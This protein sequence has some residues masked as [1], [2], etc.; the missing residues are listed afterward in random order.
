MKRPEC[1][2]FTGRRRDICNGE[3]D[4]SLQKINVQRGRWNLPPLTEAE[5]DPRQRPKSFI[6]PLTKPRSGECSGCGGSKTPPRLRPDGHGPGSQLL[7]LWTGMPHCDACLAL[8]GQMDAWGAEG[9][10]QRLNQIVA[11]I[12]PRAQAWMKSNHPWV[13]TLLTG[14]STE[15][16]V[17]KL[18]IA[19]DV[20]KAI[21]LSAAVIGR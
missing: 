16:F 1:E 7:K 21:R 20:R 12:L 10:A 15:N 17:L 19:R 18:G 4:L 8:A 11:D 2:K 14:T 3:A 9:C 13:R 5:Y 6:Q